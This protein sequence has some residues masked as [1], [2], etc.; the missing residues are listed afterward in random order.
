MISKTPS[1]SI[2]PSNSK[3]YN[4]LCESFA[5]LSA[6]CLLFSGAGSE[7]G[8]AVSFTSAGACALVSSFWI[9]FVSCSGSDPGI[10]LLFFLA[11]NCSRCDLRLAC[12]PSAPVF[13]KKVFSLASLGAAI[14]SLETG[15]TGSCLAFSSAGFDS[16][17]GAAFCSVSFSIFTLGF[18][19][20]TGVGVLAGLPLRERVLGFSGVWAPSF[21][22]PSA[23]FTSFLAVGPG[24][25]LL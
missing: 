18:E 22:W 12:A 21:F 2:I 13:S 3:E 4:A 9:G 23:S 1:E 25:F 8:F 11:S 24:L 19:E 15:T 20:A 6:F 14:F 17:A 5:V 10:L 7:T 16:A